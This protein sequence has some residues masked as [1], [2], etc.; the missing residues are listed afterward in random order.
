MRRIILLLFLIGLSGCGYERGV[1]LDTVYKGVPYQVEYEYRRRGIG[2]YPYY[3]YAPYPYRGGLEG[4]EWVTLA[5]GYHFQ[6]GGGGVYH[7]GGCYSLRGWE[8]NNRGYPQ[9]VP[10][11]A[12]VGNCR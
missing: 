8:F 9:Q 3:T 11:D 12:K 6:Y 7:R 10:S 2:Y 5:P 1:R 4:Q